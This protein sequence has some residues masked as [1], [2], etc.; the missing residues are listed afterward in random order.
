[1]WE[2][3][4]YGLS[5]FNIPFQVNTVIHYGVPLFHSINGNKQEA[6]G[7]SISGGSA[8]A[9]QGYFDFW[10]NEKCVCGGGLPSF[11]MHFW[12]RWEFS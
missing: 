2:V 6:E 12:K 3:K 5:G 9:A 7:S 10:D 4:K 8:R 1:M 11:L